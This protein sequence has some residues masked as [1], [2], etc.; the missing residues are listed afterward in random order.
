M[1]ARSPVLGCRT[2]KDERGLDG[3]L[4][5]GEPEG[6]TAAPAETAHHDL[7][8]A[9]G[10]PAHIAEHGFQVGR[11]LIGRQRRK[12]LPD[13]VAAGE[14]RCAA[15]VRRHARE[16]IRGDGN[17]TGFRKLV[18]HAAGPI[19]KT[20]ILV[21]YNDRGGLGFHLGVGDEGVYLAFAVGDLDPLGVARSFVE[22]GPGPILGRGG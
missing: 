15:A 2:I 7:A 12:C 4:V 9:R 14:V 19:C 1:R 5:G 3:R 13:G 18:G 21:D 22:A 17:I 6:L 16:Q 20:L 10:K 11:D 8:V